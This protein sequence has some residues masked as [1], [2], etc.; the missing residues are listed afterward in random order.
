[1]SFYKTIR[2]DDAPHLVRHAIYVNTGELNPEDMIADDEDAQVNQREANAVLISQN[3]ASGKLHRLLAD[4][5]L[6][7]FGMRASHPPREVAINRGS[8]S[9]DVGAC[10]GSVSVSRVRAVSFD[11]AL[12][13]QRTVDEPVAAN[14]GL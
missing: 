4:G 13:Y 6:P 7:G 14:A 10:G 5:M 11:P 3:L 12:R 8:V 1:M 2:V 9:S